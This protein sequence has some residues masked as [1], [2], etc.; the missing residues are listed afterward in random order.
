VRSYL[1][2]AHGAEYQEL[3][4][5]TVPEMAQTLR[6]HMEIMEWDGG[7]GA[8]VEIPYELA[9][10]LEELLADTTRLFKT[11]GLVRGNT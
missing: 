8:I 3:R 11:L 7:H 1:V 4:N 2:R 10:S 9:A 5:P 6:A